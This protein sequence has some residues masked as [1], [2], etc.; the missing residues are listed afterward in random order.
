M[1]TQNKIII[2]KIMNKIRIMQEIKLLI[3][4]MKIKKRKVYQIKIII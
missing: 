3:M 1:M 4:L 2:F